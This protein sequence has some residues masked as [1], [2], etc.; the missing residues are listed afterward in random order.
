MSREYLGLGR[1][2]GKI[3]RL[4]PGHLEF[5]SRPAKKWKKLKF[6]F[7]TNFAKSLSAKF[8]FQTQLTPD[9]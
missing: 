7:P 4:D 9:F 6:F 1:K 2:I 8:L 3:F 5:A